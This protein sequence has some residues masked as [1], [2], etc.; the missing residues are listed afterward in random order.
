MS[1]GCTTPIGVAQELPA[2][3]AGRWAARPADARRV[4]GW[5]AARY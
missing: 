5:R 2:R 3:Q 1:T 4:V